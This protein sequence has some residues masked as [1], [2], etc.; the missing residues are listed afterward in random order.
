MLDY[1]NAV[2]EISNIYDVEYTHRSVES[3]Q[4]G[5]LS[6]YTQPVT[7]AGNG[8][9]DVAISTFWVTTQR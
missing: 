5:F 6:P 2:T 7:D 4:T 9:A 8:I 1:F 3:E